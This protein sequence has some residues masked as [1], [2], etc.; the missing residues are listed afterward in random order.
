MPLQMKDLSEEGYERI[1]NFTDDTG[2]NCFIAIHN[3]RL[4]PALGGCRLK[5]YE[6]DNDALLDV[7]RLSKGMTYKSSLA[8]LNL[9][10]GKCVVVADKPT[11]DTMLKLGEA[12]NMLNG[13]FITGEDVGTTL[14]DIQIAGEITPYVIHQDGSSMTARGVYSC[15]ISAL[16]YQNKN[17]W[18]I[19]GRQIWIQGLGKV[20]MDLAYRLKKT[21]TIRYN[22]MEN[23]YNPTMYPLLNLYVS[24]LR[25]DPVH[26]AQNSLNA[27]EMTAQDIYHTN[28]YVPCAMGQV[29]NID[30]V[31]SLRYNIICGSANNQLVDDS[32]ADILKANNVLY[33]PD[34]LVNAGGV[35]D[36]SCEVGQQYDQIK[37]EKMTDALG[38]RLS[39]VFEFADDENITPLAAAKIIAEARFT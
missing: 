37:S 39:E 35:I 3:N 20:G 22:L 14:A 25:Y 33:C 11:R 28:I 2:F 31:N 13:E 6:T 27:R 15:I 8:G 32:Y 7:L 26:E 30:N 5:L 17:N 36:A 34:F 29:V 21:E 16:F 19:L 38:D 23:T 24:D 4:G 1:V 9:G 12:I 18:D 10:G